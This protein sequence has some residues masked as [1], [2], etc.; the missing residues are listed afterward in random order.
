MLFLLSSSS[1]PSQTSPAPGVLP[2]LLFYLALIT[3]CAATHLGPPSFLLASEFQLEQHLYF[4]PMP[5]GTWAA[6][7]TWHAPVKINRKEG[8]RGRGKTGGI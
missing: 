1:V 2:P 8:R 6:H 7:S 5:C 4:S 3:Y